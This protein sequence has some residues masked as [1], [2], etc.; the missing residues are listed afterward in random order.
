MFILVLMPSLIW[1]LLRQIHSPWWLENAVST[2]FVIVLIYSILML[3]FIHFISSFH[4]V[5]YF[6]INFLVAALLNNLASVNNSASLNQKVCTDPVTFFQFNI[7]YTEEESEL[8]ELIEHLIAGQYHLITLQGVSQQSKQQIIEK[9]SPYFPYFIR[10]ESDNQ[11]VVSDQL[12]FSQYAFTRIKYHQ[13]GG[14]SFLISSQW[15]LP[16][17]VINLHTLHPPSP[18]NEQLWQTRNKTL[19]QLKHALKNSSLSDSLVKKSLVIGDLN[20]SKHSGR[21]NILRDDMNT[22]FVNSWPNKG[23][24]LPFM[25]FA[26]DHFWV[27]KPANI[28]SR[29]RINKFSWSDHYAV[30]TEVDFNR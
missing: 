17:S 21:I 30:K 7:K 25:G 1:L 29:Q 16:F 4:C 22:K 24:V 5:I 27:S 6:F 3:I 9:L 18:R 10:G 13:R 14:S 19:Y 8:N 2:S 11:Y 28:C 26:I 23:Y 15:Q 20:L 12:L